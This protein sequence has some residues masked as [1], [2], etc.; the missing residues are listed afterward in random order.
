MVY[1]FRSLRHFESMSFCRKYSLSLRIASS[2]DGAAHASVEAARRE[3][4]G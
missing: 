3:G 2:N 1:S 4:V